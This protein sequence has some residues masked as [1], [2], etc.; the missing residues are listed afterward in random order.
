MALEIGYRSQGAQTGP[1]LAPRCR[2]RS[3]LRHG[4]PHQGKPGRDIVS[5]VLFPHF[6]SPPQT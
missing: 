2:R 4:F 5:V 6:R 1:V 3:V